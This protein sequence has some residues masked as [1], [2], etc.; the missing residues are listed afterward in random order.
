ME[1]PF[2][3]CIRDPIFETLPEFRINFEFEEE[4]VTIMQLKDYIYK[5]MLSIHPELPPNCIFPTPTI[6]NKS[7]Y[8]LDLDGSLIYIGN[9][10]F[11]FFLH[12]LIISFKLFLNA[13]TEKNLIFL[14]P[15]KT[16]K[17]SKP[18]CFQSR[19]VFSPCQTSPNSGR[20][21]R[22]SGFWRLKKTIIKWR[23]KNFKK[24]T[25][26]KKTS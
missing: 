25:W 17:N 12:S 23:K 24:K 14:G 4:E 18:R 8:T 5:E 6:P 15:K 11:F 13:L 16:T 20:N 2:F 26:P 22:F 21:R 7:L 10:F 1:H 19:R 3:E 9:F